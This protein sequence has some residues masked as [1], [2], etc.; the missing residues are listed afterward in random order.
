MKRASEGTV[1]GAGRGPAPDHGGALARGR[2]SPRRFLGRGR[3][4][5]LGAAG[6]ALGAV[7]LV[8]VGLTAGGGPA[9]ASIRLRASKAP[10]VI[11]EIGAT[12]GPFTLLGTTDELGA[13]A[14][15]ASVNRAGGVLGHK[16]QL[17][18]EN[19]QSS[20]TIAAGL[21]RK[22]VTS[23]HAQFIFGSEETATA[24]AA[25]PIANA[26]HVVML[27]WQSGWNANGY[28][29][30][31]RHGYVFPGIENVFYTMDLA[32]VQR[33]IEPRHY[34]RVGIIEDNSPGGLSNGQYLTGLAKKYGF[35]VVAQQVTQPGS[36]DDTPQALALLGAHPQAIVLGM[37][38]GP[39]TITA[40]KAIRAQNPTIPIGMCSGCTLPSFI[41]AAGN[42]T[43]KDV[44]LGGTGQQLVNSTPRTAE[45]TAAIRDTVA[46]ITAMK[47]AGFGSL[48]DLANSS[49]GWDT[50]R[51]LAAAITA[52]H[53]LSTNAVRRALQHQKIAVGGQQAIIFARTPQNYGNITGVVLATTTVSTGA[54]LKVLTSGLLTGVSG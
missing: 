11:C 10:L 3:G 21:V 32:M 22:C 29:Q 27:G 46:Y 23:D 35:N 43:M 18:K 28:S 49:E 13:A 15:A 4:L 51:E 14:W 41:S 16:V 44:Y 6:R 19:D 24:A 12:S 26:L 54:K 33:I 50:G 9:R 8:G 37:T 2:S 38:P 36:T 45:T 39:D 34:K 48:D 42:Q 40:L 53:S 1:P 5:S 30:A 17:I 7:A 20:P 31:D 25:I 47:A 52:A